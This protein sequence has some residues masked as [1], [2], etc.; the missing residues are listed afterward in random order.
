[1]ATVISMWVLRQDYKPMHVVSPEDTNLGTDIACSII[2][3]SKERPLALKNQ[4]P[5]VPVKGLQRGDW[6]TRIYMLQFIVRTRP[7]GR[8]FTCTLTWTDRGISTDAS[9]AP[10][11]GKHK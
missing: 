7:R 5:L 3:H 4:I 9:A 2:N 6:N 8:I 10:C 11:V 1:M